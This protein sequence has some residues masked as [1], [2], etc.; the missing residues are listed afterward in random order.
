MF[1]TYFPPKLHATQVPL[2]TLGDQ[3]PQ[4]L[5]FLGAWKLVRNTPKT[6]RDYSGMS[7]LFRSVEMREFEF[8]VRVPMGTLIWSVG[9]CFYD[10]D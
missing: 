10:I 8:L 4:S 5:T 3:V 9:L 6:G 2:P 7:E 1:S